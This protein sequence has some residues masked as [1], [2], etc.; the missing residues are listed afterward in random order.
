M[1]EL[2]SNEFFFANIGCKHRTLHIV[3]LIRLQFSWNE[4][5]CIYF[6]TRTFRFKDYRLEYLAIYKSTNKSPYFTTEYFAINSQTNLICCHIR[7]WATA[8]D[9]HVRNTCYDESW[10][11]CLPR[12]GLLQDYI[13]HASQEAY[14]WVRQTVQV[15]WLFI[16]IHWHYDAHEPVYD[17]RWLTHA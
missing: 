13:I 4:I 8:S 5:Y 12:K 10:S 6:Q 14:S 3:V 11:T 15:S 7:S 9:T 17:N 16:K 1:R 2:V